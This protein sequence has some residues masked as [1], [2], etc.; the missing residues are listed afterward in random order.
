M[1]EPSEEEVVL[2]RL[3]GRYVIYARLYYT[4]MWKNG[5][6]VRYLIPAKRN[7]DNV[8][9]MYDTV[10]KTFFTNAGSGAFIAGPVVQ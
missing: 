2:F 4:K 7:S 5:T 1:N 9:G 3:C 8:V 6:L 10:S